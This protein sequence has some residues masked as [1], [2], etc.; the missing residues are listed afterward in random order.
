MP[1]ESA[2]LTNNGVIVDK[3]LACLNGALSHICWPISPPWLKLSNS[4]PIS[5]SDKFYDTLL[6]CSN[7]NKVTRLILIATFFFFFNLNTK[8]YLPVNGDIVRNMVSHF[9]KKTVSLSGYNARSWKLPIHCHHALCVA[10]SCH[11]LVPYLCKYI[12]T[13]YYLQSQ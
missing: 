5:N 8:C 1:P 13:I 7:H 10:Q 12:N 3:S 6:L 2:S 11:I 4:M 9:D